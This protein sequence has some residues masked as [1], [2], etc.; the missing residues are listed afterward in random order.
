MELLKERNAMLKSIT[1]GSGKL[2]ENFSTAKD[3]FKA[4]EKGKLFK[5]L[6][7]KYVGF[8]TTIKDMSKLN[9]DVIKIRYKNNTQIALYR[10]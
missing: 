8:Y 1:I 2:T 6:D 10:I 7:G 3:A 9:I 4:F 5:V